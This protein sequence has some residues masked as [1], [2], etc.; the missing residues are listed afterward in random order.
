[1]K[2]SIQI[3]PENLYPPLTP[4]PS[5][6]LDPDPSFP[7]DTLSP[8][9]PFFTT[10]PSFTSDPSFTPDPLIFLIFSLPFLFS[11]LCAEMV[12]VYRNSIPSSK[13]NIII[14]LNYF[15][16]ELYNLMV[17]MMASNLQLENKIILQ[18]FV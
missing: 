9:D 18:H 5:F 13:M 15:I 12:R 17:S 8:L 7:P 3:I 10:D 11:N 4:D 16:V 2:Y 6:T 14:V 1:M